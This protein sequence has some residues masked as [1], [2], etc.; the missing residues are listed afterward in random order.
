MNHGIQ[1]DPPWHVVYTAVMLHTGAAL[2]SEGK[3]LVNEGML[4][5]LIIVK[6][7]D[8]AADPDDAH[9]GHEWFRWVSERRSI[10]CTCPMSCF[11]PESYSSPDNQ[12]H[13]CRGLI[14]LHHTEGA[15]ERKRGWSGARQE[16]VKANLA[17]VTK[18]TSTFLLCSNSCPCFT[19]ILPF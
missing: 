6:S 2:P 9:R 8:T 11:S 1:P 10:T 14:T 4:G 15:G 7:A 13:L 3:T 18:N 16:T 5:H 12:S 19:V 17:S